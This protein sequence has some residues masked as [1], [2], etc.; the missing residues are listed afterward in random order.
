MKSSTAKKSVIRTKSE[1]TTTPEAIKKSAAG[2]EPEPTVRVVKAGVCPSL[3]GKS[4]LGYEFGCTDAKDLRLRIVANSGAGSFRQ[5]W[6]PLREIGAALDRAPRGETVT[7]DWLLPLFRHESANMPSFVFAV[8]LHEAL[9][10]RSVKEKRRYERVEPE[11]FDATV[12]ALME[13]KGAPAVNA[14]NKKI[15]TTKVAPTKTPSAST[16]K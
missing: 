15:K 10:R 13:G 14:K 12:K 8:L 2:K 1:V 4:N 3:S 5:E 7:S 6:V 11:A 16:K 9:V